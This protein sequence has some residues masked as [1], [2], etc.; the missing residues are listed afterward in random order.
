[1]LPRALR[2]AGRETA[3]QQPHMRAALASL[4][5]ARRH[6]DLAAPDKGGH[7]VGAIAHVDA[8]IKETQ[9]GMAFDATH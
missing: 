3:A 5:E 7:R 8:A 9:A 2:A 1:L 6:L 4:R